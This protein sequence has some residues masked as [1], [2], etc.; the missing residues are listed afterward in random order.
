M[1]IRPLLACI[2]ML[3]GGC[4]VKHT[5]PGG[6]T[7]HV[8]VSP[9]EKTKAKSVAR[10]FFLA[11]F[12]EQPKAPNELVASDFKKVEAVLSSDFDFWSVVFSYSK[13]PIHVTVDLSRDMTSA[14]VSTLEM[15]G[16]S[17]GF[18][19]EPVIRRDGSNGPFRTLDDFRWVLAEDRKAGRPKY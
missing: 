16:A 9:F 17:G 3:F 11:Y 7:V 2:G 8:A 15:A 1:K 19:D 4:V 6:R 10:Q 5:T 18:R 13:D 14:R 12:N